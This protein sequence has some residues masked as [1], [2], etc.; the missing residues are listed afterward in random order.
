MEVLQLSIVGLAM[1]GWQ[2]G[3]DVALRPLRQ[4]WLGRWTRRGKSRQVVNE[5]ADSVDARAVVRQLVV[6]DS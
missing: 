3:V 5:A 2:K 4:A 1:V 6:R